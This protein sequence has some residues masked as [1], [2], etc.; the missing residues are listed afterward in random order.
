MC[1]AEFAHNHA[2]NRSTGFIPFK[3][4]YSAI[5]KGPLD[6]STVPRQKGVVKRACDFVNELQ[7]CHG[8][9]HERLLKSNE[10]YKKLA[11]KKRRSVNF[12]EGDFDYEF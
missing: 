7:Q 8:I 1:Q 9:V 5:P 10:K 3:V 11:D 12:K 6:L 4:V 2:V